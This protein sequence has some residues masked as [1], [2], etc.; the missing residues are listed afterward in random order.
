MDL[1]VIMINLNFN[2]FDIQEGKLGRKFRLII[3]QK[4]KDEKWIGKV[5]KYDWYYIFKY[6]DDG[7]M[8]ALHES[9]NGKIIE[10]LNNEQVEKLINV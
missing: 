8:F 9:V 4:G 1:R 6:I 3:T 10:K 7:S 2:T 5:L